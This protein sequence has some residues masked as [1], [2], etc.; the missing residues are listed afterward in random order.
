[1]K[2][3]R[4]LQSEE[5]FDLLII[6]GGV[7]GLCTAWDAS[8]RGLRVALVEKDD[9]THA[10]T[11]VNYKLIHGGLRYLQHLD[12]KRMRVSILERRSLSRIAPHMVTPVS[13]V[14]PCRGHGIQGPEAMTAALAINDLIGFDRNKDVIP[15]A[16]VPRGRVLSKK[17]CIALVPSLQG[18]D[19]N[20]GGLYTDLQMRSAERL[21]LS[22]G[23]SAEENGAVLANY[24]EVTE[25]VRVKDK[26]MAAR[27]RDKR[28]GQDY[29][30]S[31]SFFI[32]MTGP[33]SEIT[34]SFAT[35]TV[36]E[37]HVVRSKGVQVFTRKLSDVGFSVQ[38][39]QK[40][41]TARISRGGR[42]LFVQP[43]RDTSF[44]GQTDKIFRGNPDDFRITQEDVAEFLE[45]VNDACPSAKLTMKDVVH[46]LGGMVPVS[47]DDPNA[48][49]THVTHKY[50]IHDHADSDG[51]RNFISVNG[52]KYTIARY[53]A[54]KALDLMFKKEN[55]ESPP[56]RTAVTPV[57]GGS[58]SDV[59]AEIRSLMK[60]ED[61]TKPV[62]THLIHMYGTACDAVFTLAGNDPDLRSCVSGTDKVLRAEILHAV[63][64]EM[65]LHLSDV[66]LRRSDLGTLGC[67]PEECIQEV[68]AIMAAELGWDEERKK[69]E[70]TSFTAHYHLA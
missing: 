6:G 8:L 31:A 48:S 7:Y 4:L 2:P 62:A 27:I 54:E 65:A 10:C 14:I 26:I 61:V 16:Q 33:W 46:V 23:K 12:F 70:I 66:L 21:A 36:S 42:S 53:L 47:R 45:E 1:M 51:S 40:D 3:D 30:V 55:R 39:R 60:N 63:R 49:E 5:P 67:P 18:V 38:T 44:I 64:Q 37:K 9:F 34:K 57:V 24:S 35:G 25:L 28:S 58:I 52:V 15:S 20:G 59:D 69:E 41:T 43:W 56:C 32:N 17:E 50:E 68:A 29:E 11:A 22:M 19:L 13:F